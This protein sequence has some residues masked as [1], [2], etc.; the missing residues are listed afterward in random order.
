MQVILLDKIVHLGNVGDQ[1]NVKSGFARNFLIPQG[2]AVMA[3]KANIEHFEARRAELEA[4][5]AASLAAA[6]ARAAQVTALGSVTI[7]SKAGEEGRLFGAITT[8]DVA[9]AVTAAGV[10]IAKSE[11]RLPNGP[12]RTLGDHDDGLTEVVAHA[13]Q[14][15]QEGRGRGGVEGPGGL[16]GE[17]DL[18]AA[19]E[20]AGDGDSLLLAAGELSG[21]V[22]ET[23]ADAQGCDDGVL[24]VRV[25][26]TVGQAGGQEDVLLRGEGGQEVEGL[27]DEAELV[28]AHG[29]QLLVV[30][31]GQIA[32]GDE[33]VPGC[34][35]VQAG[36]AVQEGV[37]ARARRAHDG[38]ELAAAHGQA[39]AVQ[40]GH[41]RLAGAV[42]LGEV[43]GL[44]HDVGGR[45]GGGSRRRLGGPVREG[46]GV[47]HDRLLRGD[48]DVRDDRDPGRPRMMPQG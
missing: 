33:D 32:A 16:V 18:G 11:V 14:R 5:A 47:R 9:E 34:G 35:G 48:W 46:W 23:V 37:L 15:L 17:D 20:S 26:G 39:H 29:G 2:K 25:G 30:H 7:A 42:D 21:A 8:R 6:Q 13:G 31:A 43:P 22:G 41:P 4:A 28:A 40:G 44:D 1:V 45:G 36:Q 10:E 27:E 3:T 12:I 24:P 38:D 19:D